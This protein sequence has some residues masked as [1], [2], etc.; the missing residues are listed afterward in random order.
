MRAKDFANSMAEVRIMNEKWAEIGN[1][2]KKLTKQT[3]LIASSVSGVDKLH[4]KHE[5][6]IS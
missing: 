2:L 6:M 1:T 5:S 3:A 4:V